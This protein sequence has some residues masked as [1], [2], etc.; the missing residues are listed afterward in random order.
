[1]AT[2]D[3]PGWLLPAVLWA[4]LVASVFHAAHC[5]V[6][7]TDA[8][9]PWHWERYLHQLWLNLAGSVVGWAALYTL[10]P[11]LWWVLTKADG[12]WRPEWSWSDVGLFVVAFVGVTGY[13]PAMFVGLALSAGQTAQKVAEKV[14]K[15]G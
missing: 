15:G 3:M 13:L 6:I 1:M 8:K 7:F 4:G 5:R 12:T 9:R 10:A 11:R 14:A 2:P